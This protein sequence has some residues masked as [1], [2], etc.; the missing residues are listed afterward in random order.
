[1]KLDTEWGEL[2]TVDEGAGRPVLL[3]HPLAQC[4]ELW[5]P[6]IDELAPRA[7]VL[8][9]DARGHGASTWNG[10]AFSIDELAEDVAG[11]I[12]EVG[13]GPVAMAG[14]SMGGCVAIA[15]AATHPELVSRL[16][17][18]DTT[19]CY[20]PNRVERWEQ[21]AT[22]AVTKPRRE[23]LAFQLDRWF[24][25]EFQRSDPAEVTRAAELFVATDS[26]A[27]AQACRAL[28]GFDGRPVLSSIS[29]PTLV[30]VGAHDYATPP[31]L[32]RTLA[33]GIG[34]AAMR[35]LP[36]TRHFSVFESPTARQLLTEHL[37]GGRP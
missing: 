33:D 11:L 9:P 3:L 8:A 12:K 17:L 13:G 25:A 2:S 27:H 4:G 21:R 36:G 19:A 1:M 35:V 28:G 23:Q 32:A 14:M 26:S 30:L 24:S 7:R 34:H 31:D 37:L 18:A 5:R 22:D 15:L 16:V 20:G 6:V 29:C 10:S